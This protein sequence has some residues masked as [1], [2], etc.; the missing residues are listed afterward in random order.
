MSKKA[1]A[2]KEVIE[3]DNDNKVEMVGVVR[4]VNKDFFRVEVKMGENSHFAV[5]KPAGKLR[6]FSIHILVGDVVKIECSPYDLAK[7]RIVHRERTG[8][9][10]ISE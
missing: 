7:G 8:G 1:K 10:P 6:K 4:D 5:C 3:K 2:K 9:N